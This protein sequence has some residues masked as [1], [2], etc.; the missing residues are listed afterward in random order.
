MCLLQKNKEGCKRVAVCCF[1]LALLSIVGM[2]LV[3]IV[4]VMLVVIM[5]MTLAVIV[6]ILGEQRDVQ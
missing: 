2:I 4:G 5:G 6:G 3:V 1:V